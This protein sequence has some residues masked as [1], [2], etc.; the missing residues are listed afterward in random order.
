VFNL[1]TQQDSAVNV[2]IASKMMQDSSAMKTIAVLTMVFLPGA[3]VSALFSSGIFII[4]ISGQ[5]RVSDLSL[6]FAWSIVP[7][8]VLTMSLWAARSWLRQLAL[9]LNARAAN[10]L[11]KVAHV[12]KGQ[13]KASSP[14]PERG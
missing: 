13:P 12:T 8:T 6:P 14:D 7:L 1:V 5:W 2:N 11:T 3:F 4:D 9:D 10:T